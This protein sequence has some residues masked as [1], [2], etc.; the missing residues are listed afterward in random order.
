MTAN[1]SATAERAARVAW[2]VPQGFA[3]PSGTEYVAGTSALSWKQ[4][5]TGTIPSYFAPTLARNSA[6]KSRRMTN[7]TLPNPPRTASNTE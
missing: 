3:R 4:Y 7:T 2:A 1:G 5:S 6:S